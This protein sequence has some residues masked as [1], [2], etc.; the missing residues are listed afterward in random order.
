[1]VEAV[2]KSVDELIKGDRNSRAYR[3]MST[4]SGWSKGKS[5]LHRT[6]TMNIIKNRASE[7]RKNSKKA[8]KFHPVTTEES[9]KEVTNIDSNEI[10]NDDENI[11]HIPVQRT[12]TYL[13]PE[14]LEERDT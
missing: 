7:W 12:N 9:Q 5:K 6:E 3:R 2:G 14:N 8:K 4:E 1:M 10:K 11:P 13:D